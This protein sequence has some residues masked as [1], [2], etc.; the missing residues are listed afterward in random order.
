MT[1]ARQVVTRKT[2]SPAISFIR[3]IDTTPVLFDPV[4]FDTEELQHRGI[5]DGIASAGRGNTVFF[6]LNDDALVLRHYRR[7]GLVRHISQSRYVFT[8]FHR[9]RALREFDLLLQ[10]Q[11][12]GLPAPRAYACRV[13]R[14]G[15]LY[16]ASLVTYRL[17]GR[18][19]AQAMQKSSVEHD[20]S[21]LDD[22]AWQ[23]I[24][25]VIGQ[26]HAAGIY[27]ADLNAHNIMI[28]DDMRVS[29]IDFDRGAKRAL[30]ANP[31]RMGWCLE[32]M[33]RLERSI[34]KI[35][36][37]R[38]ADTPTIDI[39]ESNFQS[40]KLRWSKTVKS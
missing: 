24:G 14:E 23:A 36:A 16:T 26:F 19:L 15:L 22:S 37:S 33:N 11:K 31:V 27:H 4:C 3:H 35:T 8:G 5:V 17:P 9:T 38:M 21:W 32:N 29:L 13:V 18:T 34:K 25:E 10:L 28:D 1:Q 6:T 12:A 2:T 20:K 39:I 40:C 30:P 7:G